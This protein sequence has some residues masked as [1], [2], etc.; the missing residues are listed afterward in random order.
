MNRTL[1][2]LLL[3]GHVILAGSLEAA[4]TWR[5]A[6]GV[7]SVEADLV[8][9]DAKSVTLRT[10]DGQLIKVPLAKLSRA[11]RQFL[12]RQGNKKP[13]ERGAE[14]PIQATLKNRLALEFQDTPLGEA[15]DF[16][17]DT[18]QAPLFLDRRSL[19][20]AGLTD[21]T[22]VTARRTGVTLA[23]G[24]SEILEP[25]DLNWMVRHGVVFVTTQERCDELLEVRVYRARA[26]TN[27]DAVIDRVAK[28]VSPDSWQE[29]GGPA[30]ISVAGP[31]HLVIAQTRPAHE[32][33]AK[34]L[35]PGIAPVA[36]LPALPSLVEL[37]TLSK[38]LMMKV[39]AEFPEVALKDA[40][41]F[42]S[43][44]VNAD[45]VI[46]T[47][48]LDEIGLTV[49]TPVNAN[50]RGLPLIDVLALTLEQLDLTWMARRGAIAVTTP[51]AAENSLTTVRH[52]IADLLRSGMTADSI[53]ETIMSSVAAETWD[54]VGGPG[55]VHRAAT[56]LDVRQTVQVQ[57]QIAQLLNDLRS[58]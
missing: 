17:H 15:L 24:L 32:D 55:S 33:I 41:E 19:D 34:L 53:R 40:C 2:S 39:D 48:A 30:S 16:L 58:R 42:L 14:N 37:K 29:V 1:F 6:S 26:A 45:V 54:E 9:H 18:T 13:L 47:K 57:L 51:E 56:T 38:P 5:D 50:L 8:T 44:L 22:P 25:L 21:T 28:T 3:L 43:E 4:R 35:A 52:G 27:W 11:D 7:F 12:A 36:G 49:D 46:D 31:A 10:L 23:E 20:D